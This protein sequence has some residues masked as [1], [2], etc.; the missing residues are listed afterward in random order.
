M[1]HLFAI[2]AAV[3]VLA[4]ISPFA[5]AQS[6]GMKGMDMNK[7]GMDMT[8]M[9]MDKCIAM[10]GMDHDKCMA[11]M[12]DKKGAKKS[13]KNAQGKTHKGAG[14]VQ[15]VDPAGGSVTIAHGPIESMKWPSMTMSFKAK[16]KK[17]LDGIKPGAKVEFEFIQQGKNYVITAVK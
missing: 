13:A 12:K 10:Q 3:T 6:D 15:K 2:S 11:M 9:D 5:I 16:D 4:A 14:T 1:K 7:K 8:G 17:I